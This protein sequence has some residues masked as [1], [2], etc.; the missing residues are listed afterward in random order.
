ME[1]KL[2]E[3]VKNTMDSESA[4]SILKEI[5][6]MERT[7]ITISEAAYVR[8]VG[9][10]RLGIRTLNEEARTNHSKFIEDLHDSTGFRN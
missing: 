3:A 1:D 7:V 8:L 4:D 5:D 6:R 9:L 10:S 2:K